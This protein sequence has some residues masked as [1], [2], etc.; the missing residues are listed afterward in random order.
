MARTVTLEEYYPNIM[1]QIREFQKISE[2]EN[3]EFNIVWQRA[4]DVF[5]DE[6]IAD[7]TENGAMR[8]EKILKII[9]KATDSMDVRRRRILAKINRILPYTHRNLE[10]MLNVICGDG[11]S[12]VN[13]DYNNYIIKVNIDPSIMPNVEDVDELLTVVVPANLITKMV[14]TR[15]VTMSVKIGHV[16]RIGSKITI[17]PA[18]QFG[19]KHV[20][21]IGI[22][23]FV[24]RAAGKIT[25]K[26]VE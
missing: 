25:I 7:F 17:N 6:F 2:T 4:E 10:N 9:P 1:K 26:A 22:Y 15:P 3:P 19:L 13:I 24:A 20:Y 14:V 21:G 5:N 12:S 8:W 11:K 23:G 18:N 16:T